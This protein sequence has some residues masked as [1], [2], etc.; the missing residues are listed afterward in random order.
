MDVFDQAGHKAVNTVKLFVFMEL[1]NVEWIAL[2]VLFEESKAIQV[3]QIN[4]RRITYSLQIIDIQLL[5]LSGRRKLG[6]RREIP[7]GNV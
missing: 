5:N 1:L 6:V 4:K 7:L 2:G 3:D